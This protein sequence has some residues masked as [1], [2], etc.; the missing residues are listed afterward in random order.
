M[1][2]IWLQDTEVADLSP[3]ASLSDLEEINVAATRVSSLAPLAGL[4]NL[5]KL[6]TIHS[7]ISD[8]SPLAGLTNLTRLLLYDCKATDLSPLK[9]LTKLR[10]LGFPHTDNISDF[11]PLSRLT[12]LRHLDLFHTEISD[13]TPLVGL[14]NL[15]T[16]ILNENRIVD[17]SPLA[18]LL[19]LKRLEL[20]LNNISDFSPLDRIRET[21]EVF[22]WYAN[23]GFPQGGPK[24]A[25]PWLWLTLPAEK[26][27]NVLL[28]DYL[29]KV[30]NSKVTEEQIANLGASEG[31]IIGESVWSTG[32]LEAYNANGLWSNVDNLERLLNPQ[33]S[34]EFYNDE[35]FVVYGSIILYSP[36]TQQTKMFVGASHPRKVYHNSKLVHVDHA[37]YSAGE[38]AYN[39]QT[40]FPIT[41]Q[42]GKNVL[43][44]KLGKQRRIDLLSLFFGFEEGT[45]YT[46]APSGVGISFSAT[47]TTLLSGDTLM[48]D[49]N[50][51][52]ITDL[53]GWQTDITFDP[54][55]LEAVEVTEGDFLKSEGGDTFFQGGTIDNAT[56]NISTIFSTRISENGS[57][58]TGA[59][60]SVIF[61]AKA[62]G[63]TQ[64]KLENFEFVSI[65]DDIIPTVHPNITI[66]VGEYPAWDVN[67]DGRVS[68][69]DLILVARDFGS[70]ATANLRT[71]VNRDGVINIQDLII[72][73]QHMGETTD[74]AA[75]NVYVMDSKELTPAI[76]QEWIQLAQ[77]EDD[78]SLA[79]QQ[80]IE[81]LQ[82]LLAS[83]IP[84]KTALLANYPNPFNPETW[85]PYQLA[86]PA[87]VTLT[88]YTINGSVI[89]ILALGHQGAGIYQSRSR[90][91]YWDGRNDVGEFAASGIYFYTLTAGDFIA[92]R[93][94]LIL[95]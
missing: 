63:E 95:K 59:L 66:T 1:R 57:S 54:N 29:A 4:K 5:K 13:L 27:E 64:V 2:R 39:Y 18:S 90:A 58:G 8:L 47:E 79:F 16:L 25:G 89:R 10:W 15:E 55:V 40:F 21:I 61:K 76:V 35:N 68:I 87:E 44:V 80:G 17:V 78:G 34:I 26:D 31:T 53:A 50:A 42:H 73:A 19:N 33:E 24:I 83:L 60:L 20:Q 7:D 93:R 28:T 45:E 38:W 36:R 71:D 22:N 14:V 86:K 3:L 70:G 75:P 94:M 72:V 92:T 37:D 67:Q 52:N 85:I 69:L 56:G 41:L 91:A 11:S 51:E 74:S 88:I 77:I 43:L 62:A 65:T 49:L 32:I 84:E 48:L 9:D 30:S 12:E 81:N 6:D 46:V 82:R 23:P